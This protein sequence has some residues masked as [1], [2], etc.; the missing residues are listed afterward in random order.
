MK[1][2]ALQVD[3]P[4]L[5]EGAE[6]EIPLLGVFV[7]GETTELDIHQLNA[8]LVSTGQE[9]KDVTWPTGFKLVALKASAP[10]A[11]DEGSK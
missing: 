4:D 7:N 10:A 11:T 1:T 6:I 9:L 8:F 3:R 5:D 2:L